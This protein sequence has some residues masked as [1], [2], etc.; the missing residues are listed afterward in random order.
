MAGGTRNRLDV[1]DDRA[2][3]HVLRTF[4]IRRGGSLD[5][6]RWRPRCCP[7]RTSRDASRSSRQQC[8]ADRL[9]L[10]GRV[11]EQRRNRAS[12]ARGTGALGPSP[13]ERSSG[14]MQPVTPPTASQPAGSTST[15]TSSSGSRPAARLPLTTLATVSTLHSRCWAIRHSPDF[16]R[17]RSWR[18]NAVRSSSGRPSSDA[19]SSSSMPR[20][21]CRG[22]SVGWTL[23]STSRLTTRR[24]GPARSPTWPERAAS[25]QRLGVH[26]PRDGHCETSA[27]NLARCCV[28][29]SGWH[30]TSVRCRRSSRAGSR[31]PV[32]CSGD[33]SSARPHSERSAPLDGVSSSRSGGRP[34]WELPRSCAPSHEMFRPPGHK[35]AS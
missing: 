28:Q 2:H 9:D 22:S 10:A 11:P 23:R 13:T 35:W 20:T 18:T 32:P 30:S 14:S 27:W 29:Q 24:C 17:S 31:W 3:V 7:R 8:A 33:S 1:T 19:T 15:S 16:R 4:V 12:T 25:Q 6:A 5:N 26:Q 34:G 21:V